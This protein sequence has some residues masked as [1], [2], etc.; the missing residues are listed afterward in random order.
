MTS[1]P[2]VLQYPVW[3]AIFACGMVRKDNQ[4]KEVAKDLFQDDFET[5]IDLNDPNLH[6]YFKATALLKANDGLKI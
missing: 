2:S 6:N 5:C 4:Y 1:N 3:A